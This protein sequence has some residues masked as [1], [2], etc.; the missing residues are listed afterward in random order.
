M[1]LL[2]I[3]SIS[4]LATLLLS[5]CLRDD[6]IEPTPLGFLIYAN[7]FTDATAASYFFDGRFTRTLPYRQYDQSYVY[8]G[9]RVLVVTDPVTNATLFDTVV[10]FDDNTVY[11]S[12][13]YGT[14]E[15]PKLLS[16]TFEPIEGL[17]EQSAARFFHLANDVDLVTIELWQNSEVVHTYSLR[18]Q[19]TNTTAEENKIYNAVPSGV[20]TIR[21][22]DEAGEELAVS[23]NRSFSN[24]G[25]N[26]VFLVGTKD[27]DTHPLY[28]AVLN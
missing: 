14:R 4:I 6:D 11:Y 7:A 3:F 13:F 28:I 17:G 1:K 27:D 23:E 20:Y 24:G 5:G 21:A 19:E 12:F 2:K 18:E 22:L 15:E 16:T 9:N 10:R 26:T 25:Y 8:V